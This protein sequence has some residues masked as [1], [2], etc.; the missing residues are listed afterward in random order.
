MNSKSEL[1]LGKKYVVVTS[2]AVVTYTRDEGS[3]TPEFTHKNGC[4]EYFHYV[5]VERKAKKVKPHDLM[6]TLV[7]PSIS[8]FTMTLRGD[9]SKAPELKITGARG[10]VTEAVGYLDANNLRTMAKQ[11]NK[12][13][14][15]LE[16]TN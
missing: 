12:W 11:L 9:G 13:A 3:D 4:T 16:Q 2:G 6:A 14:K 5:E 15:A 7:T 10:G 8:N 1:K